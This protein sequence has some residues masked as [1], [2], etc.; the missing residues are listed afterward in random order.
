MNAYIKSIDLKFN[1]RTWDVW[2]NGRVVEGGFFSRGPASAA[3]DW[4]ARNYR[5][6]E[7]AQS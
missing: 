6:E 2:I 3:R 5:E 1:G 4:W 7:A